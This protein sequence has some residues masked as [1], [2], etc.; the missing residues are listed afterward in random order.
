[1]S[2]VRCLIPSV[3]ILRNVTWDCSL[4]SSCVDSGYL[5]GFKWDRGMKYKLFLM[6]TDSCMSVLL[7][8]D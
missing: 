5:N 4:T 6:L 8:T 1:M 7:G 2:K 3:I